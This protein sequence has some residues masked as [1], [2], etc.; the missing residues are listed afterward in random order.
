MA[1]LFFFGSLR[2]A[3]LF[4][5]VVGRSLNEFATSSAKLVGYSVSRAAHF[6]FPVVNADQLGEAEGIFVSGFTDQE[7]ERVA[8]YETNEYDLY[9][10]TIQIDEGGFETAGVFFATEH[11]EVSNEPWSLE[12]WTKTAKPLALIEAEIAMAQFGVLTRDTVNDHWSEF[13]AKAQKLFEQ[14]FGLKAS[15]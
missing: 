4:Q 8:Y 10:V 9:D 1:N 2:D 13:E 12:T 14:R 15:A 3:D 11:L 5:I 7:I 6:P